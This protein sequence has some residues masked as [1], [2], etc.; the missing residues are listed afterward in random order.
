MPK[1]YSAVIIIQDVRPLA[2]RLGFRLGFGF[3]RWRRSG[4]PSGRRGRSRAL[5]GVIVGLRPRVGGGPARGRRAP[6][7]LPRRERG[8]DRRRDAGRAR[9]L[10]RGAVA[11][12]GVRA[13]GGGHVHV[14]EF[15]R[16]AGR[17]R[18]GVSGREWR[19]VL[20]DGAPTLEVT[21]PAGPL[22][23]L[24]LDGL[25]LV[26]GSSSLT[27]LE[28]RRGGMGG[29]AGEPPP[30]LGRGG[31][32]SAAAAAAKRPAGLDAPVP[33]ED[34]TCAR[35]SGQMMGDGNAHR[36]TEGD[37]RPG[38]WT[39]FR[40]AATTLVAAARAS[41]AS[42]SDAPARMCGR[43]VKYLSARAQETGVSDEAEISA[44]LG[45]D[46]STR[47]AARRRRPCR[48]RSGLRIPYVQTRARGGSSSGRW[49]ELM[50]AHKAHRRLTRILDHCGHQK[51]TSHAVPI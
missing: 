51:S 22:V 45:G 10:V 38:D 18:D 25:T 2:L 32:L 1:T 29:G 23:P 4:P 27:V 37:S 20:R 47:R 8:R 44:A 24:R 49:G 19:S 7:V 39:C 16:E 33:G 21:R 31:D 46:R 48:S 5:R 34:S 30:R 40:P 3:P 17:I 26:G 43:A 41:A 12:G 28:A 36:L 11:D 35:L 14:A 15:L 50:L 6:H 9:G 42:S 13:F